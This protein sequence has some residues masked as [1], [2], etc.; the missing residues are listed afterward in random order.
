MTTT[1]KH[2]LSLAAFA[3]AVVWSGAAWGQNPFDVADPGAAPPAV[4]DAA[5]PAADA[6]AP[7]VETDPI[8]LMIRERDPQTPEDLIKAVQLLMKIGRADEAKALLGK[9]LAAA[10]D[11]A[12]LAALQREFGSGLFF[13]MIRQKDLHP[14]GLTLAESV[15]HAAHK[16]AHDPDR[17]RTLAANLS[18]DDGAVRRAALVD[19]REA[20]A[21]AVAP[22]V[23]I[24]AD[25]SRSSE[26]AA[27]QHA[28][29][30]ISPEATVDPLVAWLNS[31]HD[32]LRVRIVQTLGRIGD[33]RDALYL[34]RPLFA[35]GASEELKAAAR[36]ALASMFGGAPDRG[37]AIHLLHERI[38]ELHGGA[39]YRHADHENMLEIWS[40]DDAAAAPV[41]RRLPAEDASLLAE[42][43]L[44]ED[45]AAI[46]P[47]HEDS[48]KL[49]LTTKLEA[50]K[51][52]GGLDQPLPAGAGTAQAD[53]VAAGVEAVEEVLSF[54]VETKHPAAAL[55]AAEVLGILGDPLAL[56]GVRGQPGPLASAL[57][58]PDRRVRFAAAQAILQIDPTFPYP[59]A[60]LLIDELAYFASATATRRVLIADPRVQKS[61]TLAGLFAEIGFEAD[62]VTT[63]ENLLAAARTNPDYELLLIGDAISAPPLNELVQLLRRDWRTAS[64]PVGI[65]AQEA[66]ID[67]AKRLAETDPLTEAFPPPQSREGLAS[68]SARLLELAGRYLAPAD[69]RMA[70]AVFALD[71]LGRIA[72]QPEQ[73]AFYDLPSRREA[74]GRALY[75]PALTA[76]A[77]A[78]LG[79]LGDAAAQRELVEFAS[80]PTRDVQLRRAAASAFDSAVQQHGLR[81]TQ[82]QILQQYDRYNRSA[83]LDEDTQAIF[84]AILDSIEAPAKSAKTQAQAAPPETPTDPTQPASS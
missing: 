43:Q 22:L 71:A 79:Q 78:V 27:A 24:L 50:A 6:A 12:A 21:H 35:D 37:Q 58:H 20:G 54:A 19:L 14:E 63:G 70:Q 73:Y 46:A 39:P 17:L 69:E 60:S 16:A 38:V 68:Q 11:D 29:T 40:W 15:L 56:R 62:T 23:E 82:Q 36:D 80:Q 47:E 76:K 59:G 18:D 64:I 84:G 5:L 57:V 9:L 52:L 83:T 3:L 74:I 7:P 8:V 67:Y 66:R 72:E 33:A 44:A 41:Q 45:L 81:L 51:I 42:A 65:A 2:T 1:S 53:A 49:H 34:L 31:P 28:L 30:T 13:R 25:E 10:P 32:P 4:A 48:Q 61:Q 77:A 55:A 26:H 75:T